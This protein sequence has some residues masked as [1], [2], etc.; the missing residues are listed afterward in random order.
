MNISRK[1]KKSLSA[2][3]RSDFC[4]NFWSYI[5]NCVGPAMQLTGHHM[6]YTQKQTLHTQISTKFCHTCHVYGHHWLLPLYTTFSGLGLGW[7]LQGQRKAKP[8]GNFFCSKWPPCWPSGKASTLREAD[9]SSIPAFL[10]GFL[11]RWSYQWLKTQY[12]SG[13]SSRCLTV[14]SQGWGWLAGC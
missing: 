1:G 14:Q 2:D 3:I 11:F 9:L 5:I 12:S 13:N 6:W 8:F 10:M 7:G 4:G